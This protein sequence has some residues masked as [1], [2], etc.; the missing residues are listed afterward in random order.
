MDAITNL[1]STSQDAAVMGFLSNCKN[2]CA[3]GRTLVVVAHSSAFSADLLSRA[4]SVSETFMRLS[5]GKLRDRPVRKAELLK[6]DD[7]MLDRDNVVVF[8]VKP[9]GLGHDLVW[10]K[11]DWLKS[12]TSPLHIDLI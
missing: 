6:V 10:K 12:D 9:A 4:S 8:D 3:K 2:M 5:T 7:I 11:V 1:A